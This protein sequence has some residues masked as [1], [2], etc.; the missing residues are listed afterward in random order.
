MNEDDHRDIPKNYRDTPSWV[1]DH[2]NLFWW[3]LVILIVGGI[4]WISG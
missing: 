1:G 3:V 4:L 2:E